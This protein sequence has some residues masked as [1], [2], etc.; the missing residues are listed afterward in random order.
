MNCSSPLPS[1]QL[2]KLPALYPEELGGASFPFSLKKHFLHNFE[3]YC[4][5]FPAQPPLSAL[6]GSSLLSLSL[7][8]MFPGPRAAFLFVALTP[9]VSPVA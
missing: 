1:L 2:E 9:A 4:S 5:C 3:D 8:V 6:A 7:W